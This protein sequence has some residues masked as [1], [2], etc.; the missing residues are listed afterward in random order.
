MISPHYS[1]ATVTTTPITS[2]SSDESLPPSVTPALSPV[3]VGTGAVAEDPA[4]DRGRNVGRVGSVGFF[5]QHM[6]FRQRQEKTKT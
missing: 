6:P 5:R 3:G 4:V 1:T 2:A